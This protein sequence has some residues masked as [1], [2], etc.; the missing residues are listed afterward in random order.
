MK[1]PNQFNTIWTEDRLTQLRELVAL[2]LSSRQIAHRMGLASRNAVIGAMHRYGIGS[3]TKKNWPMHRIAQ[4]RTVAAPRPWQG[5]VKRNIK[6]P[7]AVLS[8]APPSLVT[9]VRP[10]TASVAFADLGF[11]ECRFPL[12]G[13]ELG[14]HRSPA[15]G[16][17]TLEGKS[18][19]AEHWKVTHA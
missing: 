13:R 6:T 18:Y 7:S 19:C 12:W 17:P 15:C 14:T 8:V 4:L 5:V 3:R 1:H 9:K 2:G 16:R 10:P 11:G